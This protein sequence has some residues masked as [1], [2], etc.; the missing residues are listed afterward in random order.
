M[1]I[2]LSCNAANSEENRE[3]LEL[4][5]CV[6]VSDH[7]SSQCLKLSECFTETKPVS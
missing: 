6:C 7:S 2:Y 1:N 5:E 4:T 3:Q